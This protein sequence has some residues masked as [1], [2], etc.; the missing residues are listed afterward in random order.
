MDGAYLLSVDDQDELP[1]GLCP[2]CDNLSPG[3][4][5][6]GENILHCYLCH[7]RHHVTPEQLAAWEQKLR[8][9][10]GKQPTE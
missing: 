6:T 4:D 3:V 5:I 8:A 7:D 1:P 10:Y 2:A 9:R